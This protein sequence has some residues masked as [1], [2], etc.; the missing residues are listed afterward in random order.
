MFSFRF[1]MS[2]LSQLCGRDQL[3]QLR[4]DNVYLVDLILIRTEELYHGKI[5]PMTSAPNKI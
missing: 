3:F 5:K 4:H 1:E 2:E